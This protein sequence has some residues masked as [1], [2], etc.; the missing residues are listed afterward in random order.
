MSADDVLKF[1]HEFL[2]R[3]GLHSWTPW[4]DKSFTYDLYE[5]QGRTCRWCGTVQ[6]RCV[7]PK[8]E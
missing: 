2:C 7:V 8:G 6:N 3:L 4:E 1:I 5:V